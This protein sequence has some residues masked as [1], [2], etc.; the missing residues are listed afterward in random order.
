[1]GTFKVRKDFK[2]AVSE[3][4][5]MSLDALN[6]AMVKTLNRYNP[7]ED[8]YGGSVAV[9]VPFFLPIAARPALGG[10]P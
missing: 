8:H 6:Q 1:M 2:N 5:I 4:A 3:S 7:G 9:R 10:S